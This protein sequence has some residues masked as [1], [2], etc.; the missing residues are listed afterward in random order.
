MNEVRNVYYNDQEF[1]R[2][3]FREII[4]TRIYFAL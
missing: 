1:K 3:E 2:K 4:L